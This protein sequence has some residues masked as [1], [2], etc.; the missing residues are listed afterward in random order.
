EPP[1][2][3]P[4]SALF[5]VPVVSPDQFSAGLHPPLAGNPSA[6]LRP[7]LAGDSPARLFAEFEPRYLLADRGRLGF[8]L[9]KLKVD[10]AEFARGTLAIGRLRQTIDKVR[11]R[12][13]AAWIGLTG[14]PII[15]Y[16]EMQASQT[17]MIWTSLV[18]MIA[19]FG[20]FI[21]GYGGLRHSLLA[22]LVLLLATAYSFGFVT[23]AVGHLNILSAAFS[24][25]LIGLGI[26][27]GI[28]YLACYLKLRGQGYDEEAALIRTSLEVGPGMF[29][30][31]VTTAAAFFMAAMTDFVGVREL[32]L[33]AGGSI[34]LC[35]AATVVV[36]PPLVLIVDRHWPIAAVPQIVPAGRWFA[37]TGRWPRLVMGASLLVTAALAA[38][39]GWLRYDH[40]LLNLQPKHLESADIERQLFTKLD[41]S[42]WYAVTMCESRDEL[43]AK[44]AQFDT[45][46]SVA[47]T[48]EIASL[49]PAST[50]ERQQ[51]ITATG[52]H[53]ATLPSQPPEPVEIDPHRL[54]TEVIR[55]QALLARETPGVTPAKALVQQLG[56]ALSVAPDDALAARL[57][58]SQAHLAR[59]SFAQLAVLR[60]LADPAP[61]QLADLPRELADRF[62]G[63]HHKLL[64]KVYARGNVW[65]MDKLE[66][67]VRDVESVDPRVTGHPVQTYYA[68]RHMQQSYVYTGLYALAAVLVLLWIDLRSLTHSLLAMAPLAVGF[69]QMCGV[70]GWCNIPLNPANMIVL[71][72]ILGIGVDH[73]VHLVHAWRQQQGPFR[74]GDSTAVAVL[75]TATT[76]TASF[77]VLILA[78][79]QGLQSL[80]QVLT[81][82]VTT[83]LFSS[84]VFFPALLGW[85]TRGQAS[86]RSRQTSEL[87]SSRSR[88]T[89][90]VDIAASDN[91]DPPI[92]VAR[93]AP[94]PS[95]APRIDDPAPSLVMATVLTTAEPAPAIPR[96]RILVERTDIGHAEPSPAH[97][98][99][100]ALRH[101]ALRESDR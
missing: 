51:L 20:L 92:A 54:R 55:A 58:A 63:A 77:G 81:I 62:V 89:S 61:P 24:A 52:Q 65:D 90:H 70:F 15:E 83:C 39:G 53:L 17:D 84:I 76:T 74:V 18:S 3:E 95:I 23:L 30:G 9:L 32:G 67:F 73:G 12:H 101:L 22:N 34:L 59:Q 50:L 97:H 40:N 88:Q 80:G 47:K 46:P 10:E 75:L 11:P 66:A 25:V 14:M 31:G 26:D 99:S 36:L 93:P 7:P 60:E 41:D 19:V 94:P 42:V 91:R 71:P 43:L 100:T 48:E 5:P 57:S 85:I 37:F 86:S 13:P 16:D 72:V 38:G 69:V 27:F 33:V 68:S 64:L 8:V 78:R 4:A 56:G 29:T 49:L 2:V 82:G 96:R 21:A 1:E 98:A 28:H 79:H 87:A 6:G 35:V 45:L 44:K